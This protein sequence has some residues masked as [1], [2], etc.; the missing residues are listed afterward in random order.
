M[1]AAHTSHRERAQDLQE[2]ALQWATERLKAMGVRYPIPDN[3]LSAGDNLER[4]RAYGELESKLVHDYLNQ[5]STEKP[6]PQP[7]KS[8]NDW[9][10]DF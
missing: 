8:R 7:T 3:N 6:K 4:I 10:D 1:S 9:R 2:K 5:S